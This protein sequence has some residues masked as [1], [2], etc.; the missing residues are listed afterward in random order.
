MTVVGSEREEDKEG[1]AGIRERKKGQWTDME[2][3]RALQ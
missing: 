1:R 2:A 3:D